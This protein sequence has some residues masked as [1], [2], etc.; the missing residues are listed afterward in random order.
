MLEIIVCF[1][2]ALSWHL[3]IACLKK[4]DFKEG[5]VEDCV[6]ITIIGYVLAI[7]I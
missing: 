4:S 6:Y 2:L 1:D 7:N 5:V 3:E